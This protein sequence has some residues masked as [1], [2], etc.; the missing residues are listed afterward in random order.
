V[1]AHARYGH[2]GLDYTTYLYEWMSGKDVPR[3][4]LDHVGRCPSCD[5]SKIVNKTPLNTRLFKITTPG[6]AVSA[7]MII[8]FPERSVSGYKHAFHAADIATYVGSVICTKTRESARHLLYFLK[9]LATVT[10]RHVEKL[11]IDGGEMDAKIVRDYVTSNGGQ[12]VINLPDV[13]SNNCIER[14]HLSIVNTSNALLAHGH[15]PM[16]LW[17]FSLTHANF[18]ANYMP[19]SRDLT[20]L[21]HPR[22]SKKRDAACKTRPPT[23]METLLC[24]GSLADLEHTLFKHL[25]PL[26]CLVTAYLQRS[27]RAAHAPRGFQAVYLGRINDIGEPITQH[28]HWVLCLTTF[29]CMRADTVLANPTKFPFAARLLLRPSTASSPSGGEEERELEGND[30]VSESAPPKPK[31]LRITAPDVYT[32]GTPV[33]T[34][35]GP[36]IVLGRYKDGDYKVRYPEYCEPQAVFSVRPHE[37]WL[38]SEYPTWNFDRDGKRIQAAKPDKQPKRPR[39]FALEP[40]T[41]TAEPEVEIKPAVGNELPKYNLRPRKARV[42]AAVQHA[43][44]EPFVSRLWE[45]AKEQ[46]G[47]KVRGLD[48]YPYRTRF[49][50]VSMGTYLEVEDREEVHIDI[51]KRVYLSRA[52]QQRPVVQPP[53]DVTKVWDMPA[54]EVEQMIPRHHHQTYSS[55]LRQYIEDAE[56]REL[57]DC[58]NREVWGPPVKV[59]RGEIVIGLM[60][61]YACK[62]HDNGLLKKFRSRI[63]LLGNQEKTLLSKVEAYAP[64]HMAITLRMLIALH[65]GDSDVHWRQLDIKNAYINEAMKRYVLCRMPP[66]YLIYEE[67]GIVLYRRLRPGEKQ[68][69]GVALPLLKALY[70]GK[71]CGRIFWEA[72]VQYHIDEGFQLIHEDRC[73]LHKRDENGSWIKFPFHVDDNAIAYKGEAF[74]ASY[75]AKL[76]QRF[77]V[78]E[79]P[80]TCHLG[81]NYHFDSKSQTVRIEQ[82]AQTDKV[83]REFGMADCKPEKSPVMTGPTPCEDDYVEEEF[84]GVRD[85]FNM[86]ALVG[87][88]QYLYMCTRPDIGYPLKV[89]SKYVRKYGKRHVLYAKHLLRYLRGTK[90]QGL[91]YASGYPLY[92]QIFTDASHASDPDTRRSVLSVV[93]KLGGNTIYWKSFYSK[94]VS[95]SSCESELMALDAGATLSELV[96]WLCHALG[97]PQQGCQQLF[98]DN[99]GTIDIGSNPVQSGR[100]LHVHARYFYVRDLVYERKVALNW[101]RTEL[102]IGDVGCSYK[103]VANFIFLRDL[104]IGCA[105]VCTDE[106]GVMFWE[107]RVGSEVDRVEPR[108]SN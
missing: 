73:Y 49:D 58:C 62:S 17:E 1:L 89:L 75:L 36:A 31:P 99:Q 12:I 86:E 40:E 35:G 81:V 79:G 14:R 100:N 5:T 59:G 28:G 24:D 102:Q 70:G 19:R 2:P 26:F 11:Y 38:P 85:M 98:I 52:K 74:Y 7:D 94:I 97:G 53:D 107:R 90:A 83:L 3:A 64:V 27:Q 29:R 20:R 68:P 16:K 104:I 76:R 42:L 67:N 105:R 22:R 6:A 8:D 43:R 47:K 60:W 9:W 57:Q 21:G 77:D 69:E 84:D 103:G 93:V 56:E 13:H 33:M 23:P 50:S 45:E 10:Q 72:F 71:E 66:G 61:V 37:L 95:H 18:L 25:H 4:V 87:H 88:C 63:T 32:E 39:D 92:T 46:N 82:E 106:N 34:T 41:K 96:R 65:L 91:Y 44:G 54:S 30:A 101:I 78:E 108:T 80:L 55:P 48:I 51:K 15:A